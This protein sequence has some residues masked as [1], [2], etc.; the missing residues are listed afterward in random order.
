MVL[1][2]EKL[3]ADYG[4]LSRILQTAP[5]DQTS[6]HHYQVMLE[7]QWVDVPDEAVLDVP[8]KYGKALVWY[9]KSWRSKVTGQEGDFTS[10]ASCR[11]S[12][13][14]ICSHALVASLIG[15]LGSSTFR[16]STAA[17][18][19]CSRARAS[20]RNRH[21]G[22]SI[23]GF[24][25]EAEQSIGRPCRQRNGGSKRPSELTSSIVPRGT[26]CHTRWS[27]SFLL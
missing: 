20:L 13:T 15:Y 10:A 2:T 24:E 19:C 14:E 26:S 7:G 1:I 9:S 17:C 23:M 6:D 27:S 8:N 11:A 21:Q 16:L 5:P 12:F 4:S 18:R 3:R 22:P 25:D